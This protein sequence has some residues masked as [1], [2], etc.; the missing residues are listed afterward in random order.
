M[1]ERGTWWVTPEVPEQQTAT[2][3]LYAWI[4]DNNHPVQHFVKSD[5]KDGLLNLY[6]TLRSRRN[7]GGLYNFSKFK[8]AFVLTASG[9]GGGSLIYSNLNSG[10]P[11]SAVSRASSSVRRV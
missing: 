9:V 6:S 8:Q 4:K 2:K 10:E 1:L 3:S 5:D 11:G 7:K